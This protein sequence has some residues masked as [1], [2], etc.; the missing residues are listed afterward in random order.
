MPTPPIIDKVR[1]LRDELGATE[2]RPETQP[3]LDELSRAV[4]TVML[5]PEHE[6]HYASLGE[7]LRGAMADLQLHHP[8]LAGAMQ[9]VV[10][11]LDSVGL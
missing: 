3:E 5:E 7:R 8:T 2:P 9:Q 10:S 11:A 4:E 1:Q 6:P